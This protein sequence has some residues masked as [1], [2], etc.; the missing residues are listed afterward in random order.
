MQTAIPVHDECA[1]NGPSMARDTPLPAHRSDSGVLVGH[2][3]R[4]ANQG[5]DRRT[6]DLDLNVRAPDCNFI[7]ANS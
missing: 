2:S 5:H 1:Q 4:N 7:D 3:F 6:A